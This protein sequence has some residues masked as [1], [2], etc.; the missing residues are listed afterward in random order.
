MNRQP[1][2]PHKKGKFIV[3]LDFELMWGVRDKRTIASY[4]KNIL[5][6]REVIPA[7]LQLFE[8]YDIH[9]TF[10]TVGFLFARNKD[11]LKQYFPRLSNL[12]QYQL[13]NYSPYENQY[14]EAIGN[15]EQDD[16]YHYAP[17]LIELIKQAPNQEIAS[18]TFS[19]YYCLEGASL[20]SFKEDMIAAKSIAAHNGIDI[21]TIIFPRNQYSTDHI[22]I[23]SEL[24]F[25]AYRGNPLSKF[26]DPRK[27]AEQSHLIRAIRLGD[28]YLNITGHHTFSI[29]TSARIVDIPASSFLRP[30]SPKLRFMDSLRIKRIKNSMTHAAK[31]R[32]CYHLWWHPHNFGAYLHENLNVLKEIL[33]HFMILRDDYGMESKS[34]KELAEEMKTSYGV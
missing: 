3:S 11:E 32:D 16:P 1:K 30:Y 6:V 22:N 29:K 17:S 4:G 28:A 23:C 19:H 5:G 7:L 2:E 31:C 9:A 27:N 8:Q 14:L 26:Y 12:P 25:T 33:D 20:N 18:H 15:S 24:G 21:T 34:M 13:S 10:A